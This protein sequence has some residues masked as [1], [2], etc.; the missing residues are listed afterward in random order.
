MRSL[1]LAVEDVAHDWYTSLKPLSVSSWQQVKAELLAT[2]QGYQ[3]GTKTTRDLL[4]WTQQDNEPLSEYLE[5]FIELKAQVP[6]VPEATVIATAIEG[7]AIGQCAAHFAREPPST[8]KELFE[9]MRQYPRSDDDFKHR[10]AARNQLRQTTKI[11]RDPQAPN[12]RNV[13]PLRTTNN[14]EEDSGQSAPDQPLFNPQPPQPHRP[15]NFPPRGGRGGCAHGGQ[16]GRGRGRGS[17]PP[18]CAICGE[19]AGHY[20]RDCR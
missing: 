14:L 17:R 15:F 19:N 12:Q 13:R 4:N 10:K 18:Y 16:D 20:T 11:P 2:F 9:V 3:L 8:M 7:L 5:R 1:I 6:N